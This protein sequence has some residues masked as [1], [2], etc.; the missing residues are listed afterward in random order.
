[1]AVAKFGPTS[2]WAGRRIT[3]DGEVFV[4]QGHGEIPPLVI[5]ENDRLGISSG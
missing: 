3:R 2:E 1:M 5:M 4:T